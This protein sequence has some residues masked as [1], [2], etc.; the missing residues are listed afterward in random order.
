MA[1]D[2][3]EWKSAA[4]IPTGLRLWHQLWWKSKIKVIKVAKCHYRDKSGR[5]FDCNNT[6]SMWKGINNVREFKE[7]KK[8]AVDIIDTLPDVLNT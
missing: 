1:Q 8:S 6:R 2:F 4:Q 3:F 5:Q 7:N